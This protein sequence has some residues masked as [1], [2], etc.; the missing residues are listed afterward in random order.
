MHP[1]ISYLLWK[2]P[3]GHNQHPLAVWAIERRGHCLRKA[4]YFCR[5]A[6]Q[7]LRWPC[8]CPHHLVLTSAYSKHIDGS[9]WCNLSA[10]SPGGFLLWMNIQT[11]KVQQAYPGQCPLIFKKGARG[12]GIQGKSIRE[13]LAA[14]LDVASLMHCLCSGHRKGKDA[15]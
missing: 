8:M 9:T 10:R 11:F 7:K 12:E 3:W 15:A 5:C 4:K 2:N 14:A 6:S 13:S 1:T